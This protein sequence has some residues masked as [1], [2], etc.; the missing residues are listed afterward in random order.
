[1]AFRY[2][3]PFRDRVPK[4]RVWLWVDDGSGR[5]PDWATSYEGAATS[6]HGRVAGPWGRDGDDLYLLYTGGTTGMP[7]GV[8]W[9]Q[10]DF[11]HSTIGALMATCSATLPRK[12]SRAIE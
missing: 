11:F 9:R 7:K 12:V 10:E 1:V 5:C 8:M 2:R 3:V 6:H 4:V